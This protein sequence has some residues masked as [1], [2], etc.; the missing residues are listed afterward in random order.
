MRHLYS[1]IAII[2]LICGLCACSP[3]PS[4]GQTA[5]DPFGVEQVAHDSMVSLA[6]GVQSAASNIR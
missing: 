6:G 3:Q 2:T 5:Q 1:V 4:P